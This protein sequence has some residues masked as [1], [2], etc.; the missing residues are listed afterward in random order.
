V[1]DVASVT[2][3]DV[4]KKAGVSMKTVSRVLNAE[5]H[6]REELKARVLAAAKDLR[7]R[8][9]V[10]ARSL[11][12]ARSY[13]VGF[14]LTA[15]YLNAQPFPYLVQGQLGALSACRAAGYHLLVEAVDLSAKDILGEIE[16][17]TNALTVDG[18][19][20]TPPLCDHARLLDALDR[21]SVAY[22]RIAPA[23]RPNRSARV[24][25]DDRGAAR[26]ITRH[27]L[28][29]GHRRI[30]FVEGPAGHSASGRR[31]QGFRDAMAERG[32]TVDETLLRPGRFT[33][34]SGYDAAAELLALKAPPSAIF[35]S[36]DL[37]AFG[38]MARAHE[39]GLRVPEALSVAGFDDA[40]AAAMS[41]PP[42]T[43]MRQPVERMTALA[44]ELII[45][46]SAKAAQARPGAPAPLAC[47]LV[48]R[49][50]TAPPGAPG[51]SPPAAA[52]T[53][54]KGR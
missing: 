54:R 44:V 13:V 41:W 50:S 43:T 35:A 17:L 2:I 51:A 6:V 53:S 40:A 7:Y 32:A 48:V 34:S 46:G 8:P 39:L 5:P 26:I 24:D 42:L 14:L 29:L 27:L 16:A 45:A 31:L 3:T 10:S 28:D 37:M 36:N 25:V 15:D 52:P 18:L 1:Y 12:G 33:F 4:A 38:V 20:L 22:V 47:E 9:K 11:A 21:E 49:A 30:G 23:T 19:I